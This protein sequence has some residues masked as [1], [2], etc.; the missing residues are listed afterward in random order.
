MERSSKIIIVDNFYDDPDQVRYDAFVQP[1]FKENYHPGQ[2]TV[3]CFNKELVEKLRKIMKS[4][5]YPTGDSYSY[6]YNVSKD[7]S[8][9]HSDVTLQQM[10]SYPERKY[11]AAVIYL[12][13]NPP[14][15][16]GTSIYNHN[17]YGYF[18]CKDIMTNNKSK[19]RC[20]RILN[21]IVLTG[22]DLSKWSVHTSLGN[23]YNRCVIYDASYFHQSSG[24]FGNTKENG[25]LIQ[26]VFFYII[27]NDDNDD[28]DI[29][30][31]KKD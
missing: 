28:D 6:Q 18:N 24:Y 16:F 1:L 29:I 26:L 11:F 5:I 15:S 10:N 27:K 31:T 23:K 20:E 9:I 8:W 25:R 13:P 22:S 4:F 19:S 30:Y 7:V 21:D 14:P 12:T 17:E 3:T 2:R